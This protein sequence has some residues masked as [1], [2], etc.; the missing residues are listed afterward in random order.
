MD[1][2]SDSFFE[3]TEISCRVLISI[4][5]VNFNFKPP[6]AQII[7]EMDYVKKAAELLKGDV[8]KELVVPV[9][10]TITAKEI[11]ND[12]DGNLTLICTIVQKVINPPEGFQCFSYR[13]N[14]TSADQFVE[15]RKVSQIVVKDE[16]GGVDLNSQGFA[17]TFNCALP[18]KLKV[19]VQSC[20]VAS[21]VCTCIGLLASLYDPT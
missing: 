4:K 5:K 11:Q 18:L 9:Y 10:Q 21:G 15:L 7:M 3:I 8:R 19:I 2:D 16:F 6:L 13:I 14:D 12:S 20:S 1:L 17:A